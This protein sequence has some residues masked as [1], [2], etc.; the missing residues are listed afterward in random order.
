MT[1]ATLSWRHELATLTHVVATFVPDADAALVA[2][3]IVREIEAVGRPKLVADLMAASPMTQ[4]GAREEWGLD[5][6]QEMVHIVRHEK[7]RRG[8]EA[9]VPEHP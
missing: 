4:R 2:R 5:L 7:R 8:S 6:V 9:G 3:T 1:V